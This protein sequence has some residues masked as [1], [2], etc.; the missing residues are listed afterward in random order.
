VKLPTKKSVILAYL[1]R[2]QPARFGPREAA[3]L[4]RELRRVR[5]P[6]G[7]IS[8]RYLLDVIEATEVEVSTELGGL[9]ADLRGL[10]RFDTLAGAEAV[11]VQLEERRRHA[12][13]RPARE[14]LQRAARRARERSA[15]VARNPRV[16]RA[17]RWEREE[18]A[19]WFL[20]WLKTP[21]LF[22]GWLEL[23]K[24]SPEFRE[25]FTL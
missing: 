17:V 19:Q 7:R 18:I 13:D 8:D 11:L 24:K 21:K 3:A 25:R 5:G 12:A 9:P 1:E 10:L 4:R 15:L 22:A 20:V 16:H 23:R 2:E 14:A 6:K